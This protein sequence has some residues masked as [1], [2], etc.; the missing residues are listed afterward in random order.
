MAF[1]VDARGG[2]IAGTEGATA[3]LVF[4]CHKINLS[5]YSKSRRSS[6]RPQSSNTSSAEVKEK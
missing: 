4:L 3:F 1:L 5:A 2:Q 6:T